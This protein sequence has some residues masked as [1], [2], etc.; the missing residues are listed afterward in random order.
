MIVIKKDIQK[1]LR[2]SFEQ[3]N[4]LS[5]HISIGFMHLLD[6]PE[7]LTKKF[8]NG[9]IQTLQYK[10]NMMTM[11]LQEDENLSKYLLK[12]RIL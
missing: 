10:T 5:S 8:L 7:Q 6:K 12:F 9:N 4:P 11:N 3:N 2:A 1:I